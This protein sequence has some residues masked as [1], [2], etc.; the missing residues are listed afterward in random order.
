M[1]T[2]LGAIRFSTRTSGSCCPR[3]KGTGKTETPRERAIRTASAAEAT[4]S[5]P[6]LSSTN[7]LA[8]STGKPVALT[9]SARATLVALPSTSEVMSGRLKRLATPCSR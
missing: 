6:S 7:R 3:P 2:C 9:C 1:R 5:F 4:F 8:P